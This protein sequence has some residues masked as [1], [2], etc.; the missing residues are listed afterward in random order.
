MYMFMSQSMYGG[1]KTTSG[2]HL[3]LFYHIC[4]GT[5]LRSLSS[6]SVVG[7]FTHVAIL[8]VLVSTSFSLFASLPLG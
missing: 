6:G 1:R 8:L 5:E 3:S 2:S 4:P 7:T